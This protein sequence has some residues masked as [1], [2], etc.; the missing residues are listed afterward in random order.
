MLCRMCK[1]PSLDLFL[2][3][4][5]TPP[6]DNFL[7]EKQLHESETYYPLQVYICESC[8]LSQLG[9]VVPAEKL[10]NSDYPY[11]SSTTKTGREHFFNMAKKICEKFNLKDNSLIVDIG[12]N[13]GV[14]LQGFKNMNMRVIGVEPSSNIA[15]SAI[16]NGVETIQSFFDFSAVEKILKE[17]QK[18]SIITATNVFAHVDDL[19]SFMENIKKLLLDDGVFIFEAPYFVNLIHNLEY[20]TIYHEHLSYLS[21]KPL[22]SFFKRFEMELFE[23]EKVTIHGGSIRCFVAKKGSFQV[24]P[25][26]QDMINLEEKENMYSIDNLRDFAK[27]VQEHRKELT[28]TLIDIKSKGKRVICISA[29]AKGMT[30]LNYCKIDRTIC[31]YVTEKSHLKIGKF[32]P[33]THILVKSDDVLSTDMPDYALL[34][35]W[36]F[37]EEIMRNLI[38]FKKKGGKF[39]IPIPTVRIV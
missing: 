7:T 13:V 14:L 38:D 26:I 37:A 30:L 18:A 20:D 3:L 33:G 31:D 23:V 19:Y 29:P 17:N 25:K 10:F 12:S 2:D 22:V 27:K 21:I 1:S 34:L 5:F 9:Y 32:T 35:A 15:K 28:K 16:D 24:S 8:G 4:D 11:E 39:I 36:N 6:A